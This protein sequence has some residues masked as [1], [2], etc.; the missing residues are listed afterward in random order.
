MKQYSIQYKEQ[1]EL[2]IVLLIDKGKRKSLRLDFNFNINLEFNYFEPSINKIMKLL[3]E[4]NQISGIEF[5]ILIEK[6]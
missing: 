1:I 5:N 4:S 3:F 2:L 6:Q